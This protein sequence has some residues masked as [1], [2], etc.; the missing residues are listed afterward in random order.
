MKIRNGFVSN[1]SSS[2][3]IIIGYEINY[4]EAIRIKEQNL[5]EPILF[6]GD[7]LCEGKDVIDNISIKQLQT[8]LCGVD[9]NRIDDYYDFYIPVNTFN[10]EDDS[11]INREYLIDQLSKNTNK[12]LIITS[13]RR[14]HDRSTYYN[15]NDNSFLMRYTQWKR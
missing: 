4:T 13:V 6:V 7:D 10:G 8:L 3:F 2:S 14:D 11:I 15:D 12:N 1:S 9:I 5:N